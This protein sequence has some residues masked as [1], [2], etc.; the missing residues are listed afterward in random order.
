VNSSETINAIATASGYNPSLV[1][2]AGFYINPGAGIITTVAGDGAS[3]FAGDGS[4]ATSAS[5]GYP[6]GVVVDSLG[7]L[8]IADSYNARIRKVNPSGIISTF[9]GTGTSGYS[10]DGGQAVNAKLNSPRGLA[11]DLAGNLYVVDSGNSTVRKISPAGIITTVAGNGTAGF[12]GDGG[13]ANAAELNQ[14][15]GVAVDASGNVYIAD[16]YNYRIRK[17]TPAGI[18]TTIAGTG[19]YGFTGD[20]GPATSATMTYPISITVD[21]AGNVYFGDYYN[22]RVR[23][24][25]TGGTISTYAGNSYG[26]GGDGS[27]ATA[28]TAKIS[29][30]TSVAIDAAGN[31]YI[32]D[33]SNYRIRVVSPAGILS[34]VSGTGTYGFT[35]DAGPAASA[36]ISSVYGF[37]FDSKGN[38]YFSDQSNYRIRKITH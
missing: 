17:V 28:S 33:G 8:Y 22:Y 26:F 30:P 25:S 29:Y 12:L 36:E 4:A 19:T 14:P 10:G 11:L 18:I 13:A 34:T 2:T 6:S 16:Y 5:L 23:K 3:G 1:G 38:V 15:Y 27:S 7:N 32:G 31:L 35:G 9:A 37:A 20:G 21:T 24:I